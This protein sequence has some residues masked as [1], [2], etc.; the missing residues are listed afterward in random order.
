[1]LDSLTD[2]AV[3]Y[4]FNLCRITAVYAAHNGSEDYAPTL[5]DVRMA[6]QHVGAL[7]PE[8]V[9]LEQE[10]LGIEDTRGTDDFIEWA[11]GPVNKEIR[12]VALDGIDDANDYLNGG[13]S[14]HP[15]WHR[16]RS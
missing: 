16:T 14:R 15:C 11:K 3:R 1:V 7:L 13:S 12:R 10:F 6:L 5:V 9:Q 4:F 2:L 8:K